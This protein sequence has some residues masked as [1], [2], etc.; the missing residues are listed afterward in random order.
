MVT[1]TRARVASAISVVMLGLGTFV[2][3][4]PLWTSKGPLTDSWWLDGGFAFFFIVRGA[5]G[6]RSASRRW[7]GLGGPSD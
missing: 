7:P 2:A 4:R 3:L 5:V 1:S 6:V